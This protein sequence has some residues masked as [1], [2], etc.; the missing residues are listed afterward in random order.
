M[1][2]PDAPPSDTDLNAIPALPQ[3]LWDAIVEII[4]LSEPVWPLPAAL[5]QLGSLSRTCRAL[6]AACGAATWSIDATG[7]LDAHIDVLA[8]SAVQPA[9]TSLAL[10]AFENR[11]WALRSPPFVQRSASSLHCLTASVHG[12]STLQRFQNLETLTLHASDFFNRLYPAVLAGLPSLRSLELVDYEMRDPLTAAVPPEVLG[13]LKTL[14]V[15][16]V[17]GVSNFWYLDSRT[18]PQFKAS[19]DTFITDGSF[20]RI[21]AAE[22]SPAPSVELPAVLASAVDIRIEGF[23]LMMWDSRI[24]PAAINAV[25]I[26]GV[27]ADTGGRWRTL[28]IRLL[29]GGHLTGSSGLPLFPLANV[30]QALRAMDPQEREGLEWEYGVHQESIFEV[31]CLRAWR[32]GRGRE[33]GLWSLQER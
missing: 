22:Y 11:E 8:G 1:A 26:A 4:F 27:I 32:R 29:D 20:D 25:W 3:F 6:R 7:A 17:P 13:G 2:S 12:T 19:L 33:A 28:E 15:R 31:C 16:N 5:A 9:A 14:I 18:D 21:Q 24:E 30:D 10:G 23:M